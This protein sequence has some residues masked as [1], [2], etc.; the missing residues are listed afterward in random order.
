MPLT[1]EQLES[2]SL[3]SAAFV[4]D[5]AAVPDWG[6][7]VTVL[8]ADLTGPEGNGTRVM[9][10]VFVAGTGG[11]ARV[12]VLDG[13]RADWVDTVEPDGTPSHRPRDQGRVL[14]D[15]FV[16]ADADFRGGLVAEAVTTPDGRGALWF[17]WGIDPRGLLPGP[18]LARLAFDGTGWTTTHRFAMEPEY[19]G[20]LSLHATHLILTGAD[21][22]YP[23]LDDILVLPATG[24]GGAP[25]VQGYDETGAK[26]FDF[27]AG[28]PETRN[29]GDTQFRLSPTLAGVLSPLSGDVLS[30]EYGFA[31]DRGDGV[32]WPR[33]EF[34][35]F[36]S[37]Q[38]LASLDLT[39]DPY[40]G[41]EAV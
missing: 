31:L 38:R 12:Q 41:W 23:Q 34:Y 1:V 2:R 9:E 16:M 37:L 26:V 28:D 24:G 13:G 8:A 21:V 7:P 27:F 25:R 4:A 33:V 11:G 6:V 19:R 20:G 39:A 35:G 32:A 15:G 40:V 18:V 5:I 14:Y 30:G 22:G 29:A 17:A 3:M 10:T 36:R